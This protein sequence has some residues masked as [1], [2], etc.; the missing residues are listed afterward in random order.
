MPG[1]PVNLRCVGSW[2]GALFVLLF[3][4]NAQAR[5]NGLASPGCQGCH[6]GGAVPSVTLT[7]DPAVL[8]PGATATATITIQAKNGP[9]AGM[10]VRATTGTFSL[11]GGQSTALQSETEVTHSAPKMASG[12]SVVFQTHWTAPSQPGGV[13]FEVWA[14]SAN[15]DGRPSGDGEGSTSLSLPFGCPGTPY[16]VDFD[17]DGFAGDDQTVLLSC[18]Q[19]LGFSSVRG[20]C[21]DNDRGIYPGAPERCNRLDDNCNGVI[22]EGLNTGSV[23]LH[24]D[25]DGDGYGGPSG[26]T[27]VVQG[28]A[29]MLGFAPGSTDC[30]DRDATIHPGATDVCNLV[31]DNCDGRV[32]ETSRPTCGSGACLSRSPTCSPADCVPR[33]AIAEVCNAADDD[34]DG[35]IDNGD[36]LCASGQSCRHGLCLA[37]DNV[38]GVGGSSASS[39]VVN[40]GS[41]TGSG[42]SSAGNSPSPTGPDPSVPLPIAGASSPPPSKPANCALLGT[43]AGTDQTRFGVALSALLLIAAARRRTSSRAVTS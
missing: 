41:S 2:L 4:V 5:R 40:G 14:L 37:S 23:T 33:P 8:L 25:A 26:P 16:Y 15:N 1:S 20:D 6:T 34:C 10:Y 12:G 24:T 21:N 27:V 29:L 28:C 31:D 22:D 9:V 13:L 18:T 36:G 38:G 11:I 32:D 30:N 35:A 19:P 3:A 17:G 42:T 39:G 43:G 7:T